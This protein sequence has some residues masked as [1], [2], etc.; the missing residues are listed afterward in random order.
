M[1]WHMVWLI[2]WLCTRLIDSHVL[3]WTFIIWRNTLKSTVWILCPSPSHL[4]PA[5]QWKLV[6]NETEAAQVRTIFELYLQM[7]SVDGL[8]RYLPTIGIMAKRW[9]MRKGR[10]LGGR[11]FKIMSL[12]RILH[13]KTYLGYVKCK[14]IGTDQCFTITRWRE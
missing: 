8:A 9:T 3:Y 2:R 11:P 14:V 10:V 6:V 7:K 4:T 1:I 12:H 13:S 5:H